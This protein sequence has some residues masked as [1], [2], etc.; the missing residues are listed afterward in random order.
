MRGSND[1]PCTIT[2]AHKLLV[3]WEGG[4]YTIPSPSNGGISYTTIGYKKEG[5]KEPNNKE[6]EVLVTTG[7]GRMK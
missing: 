6:G 7:D 3:G 1:Y 2:A 5:F 4:A